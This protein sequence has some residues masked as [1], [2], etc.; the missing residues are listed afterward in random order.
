MG[1]STTLKIFF[2][3][4]S[5]CLYA[6]KVVVLL[7]LYWNLHAKE[8]QISNNQTIKQEYTTRHE[9][10]YKMYSLEQTIYT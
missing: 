3:V 8:V 10:M 4:W 2:P 6:E 1:N 5:M 7:L 9:S